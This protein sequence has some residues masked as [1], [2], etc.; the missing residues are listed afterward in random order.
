MLS[1]LG[2]VGGCCNAKCWEREKDG[3]SFNSY[4]LELDYTGEYSISIR[5]VGGRVKINRSYLLF[6]KNWGYLL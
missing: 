6:V 1:R 4:R 3:L 2:L 5:Q